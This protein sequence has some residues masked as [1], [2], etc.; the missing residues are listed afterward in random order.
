MHSLDAY[1]DGFTVA[2]FLFGAHILC[3]GLLLARTPA[4]PRVL[5]P[6]LMVASL[7]F[8]VYSLDNLATSTHVSLF[9]VAPS[10]LGEFSLLLWLLVKPGAMVDGRL[11]GVPA[12]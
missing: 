4:A 12:S 3:L 7:G 5:G 2:L 1:H 9:V 6:W 10:A 8:F 11:A